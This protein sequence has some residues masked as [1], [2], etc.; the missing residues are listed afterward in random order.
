MTAG[1]HGRADEVPIREADY[2]KV[3]VGVYRTHAAPLR[4]AAI[5]ESTFTGRDNA[6]LACTVSVD[7]FGPRFLASYTAGDNRDVVAT[8]TMKNFVLAMALEYDGAT[9]EGLLA[10]LGRRFLA[11]YAQIERIRLRAREIPFATAKRPDGSGSA[12]LFGRSRADVSVAELELDRAG[13]RDHRAG[14]EGLQLARLSGSSFAGFARDE[15]TT[16][17]ETHDRPLVLRLDVHWRYARAEDALD[18]TRYVPSEQVRDLAAH[19]VDGF[20]SRSIQHL[21]H[22]VGQRLLARFAQ[23]AEVR[24]EAQNRLWDEARASAR[25]PKAKVY[26][27]PRPTYGRIGLTLRR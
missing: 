13:I 10:F 22:E 3:E 26:T 7:V 1:G 25:D 15:Y 24:L 9:L 19:V 2:G 27:D 6:L 14:R 23:L 18:G 21:V 20:A 16:L 4:V 5:P 17:P 8:D 11:Q 12:V